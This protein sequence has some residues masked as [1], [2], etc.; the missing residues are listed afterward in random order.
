MDRRKIFVLCVGSFALF[1]VAILFIKHGYGSRV[2]KA[3]TIRIIMVIQEFSVLL[4]FYLLS[5]ESIDG[6]FSILFLE[7]N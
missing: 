1:S 5:A 7:N 4:S 3:I 6:L 2:R